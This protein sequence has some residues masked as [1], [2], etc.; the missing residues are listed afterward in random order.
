MKHTSTISQLLHMYLAQGMGYIIPW[1]TVPF[2]IRR[3]GIEEFGW[4]ALANAVTLFLSFI[5]EYSFGSSAPR[6][7]ARIR[8]ER[9]KLVAYVTRVLWTR[10]FLLLIAWTSLILV[11]V[12]M[13]AFQS[14]WLLFA[15]A[16]VSLLGHALSPAYFFHGLDNFTTSARLNFVA[17]VLP[18]VAIF[19]LVDSPDDA[20]LVVLI[21]SSIFVLISLAGLL[22]FIRSS[23]CRLGT[24]TMREILGEL[25]SG[26]PLSLSNIAV[27]VYTASGAFLLGLFSTIEHVGYYRA[28]EKTIRVVLGGLHL[29]YQLL[30]PRIARLSQTELLLSH[31]LVQQPVKIAIPLAIASST[32]FT[33]FPE[34]VSKLLVGE[35]V[36]ELVWTL[37][38]LGTLPIIVTFTY[39]VNDTLHLS[40]NL[41]VRRMGILV[42][43]AFLFII[44]SA[45]SLGVLDFGFKGLALN[46]LIV[47]IYI[48]VAS[49]VSFRHHSLRSGV[50]A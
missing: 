24:S 36:T 10:C 33:V 1:L 37:R 18:A 26:L 40:L 25:Q 43:A 49:I 30:F 23:D 20:I 13:P 35:V 22:Y 46:V 42:S 39:L 11:L 27:A 8:G 50:P 2:L 3:L 32:L 5:V 48:L 31:P 14:R 45:V 12:L 19:L 28:A 41:D 47:E 17:R 7:V 16:S 6:E 9:S 29:I 44:S 38:I 21:Q 4:V 15:L 34:V